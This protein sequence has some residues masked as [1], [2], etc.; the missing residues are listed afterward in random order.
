MKNQRVLIIGDPAIGM[1]PAV[2]AAIK[3]QLGNDVV[4]LTPDEALE[5]SIPNLGSINERQPILP[6]PV[7]VCL[8]AK[9]P[10]TRA[11]KRA[12][13]RRL[14]KLRNRK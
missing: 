4:V 11:E 14:K 6:E 10:K 7:E 5:L 12:E 1:S 13:A 3:A 8:E 2:I 9:L